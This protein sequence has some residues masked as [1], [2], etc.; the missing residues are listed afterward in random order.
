MIR[1][2]LIAAI[3][4]A[5]LVWLGT[6][7]YSQEQPCAPRD[8]VEKRIWKQYGESVVGAGISPGGIVYLTANPV[9]GTWSLLIRRPDGTACVM[10]G[11]TGFAQGEP[12]TPGVGL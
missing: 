7:S 6:P 9:T 4:M 12:K 11:G 8:A 5:F 2:W 10:M 1:A 3:F